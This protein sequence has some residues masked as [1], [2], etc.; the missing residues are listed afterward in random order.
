[1]GLQHSFFELTR[2]T[3]Q[4]Q[5]LITAPSAWLARET[6]R[7]FHVDEKRIHVIP[8]FVDLDRFV[9]RPSDDIRR[10]LGAEDCFVVTHVSNYRP[11][12]H[13]KDVIVGF[14]NLRAR[15]K[16]VLVLVGDGPDLDPAVELAQEL[17]V[18]GDLRILGKMLDLER[19]LQASDL[20]F[21]PSRAESFGLAAL[22][23][24][25]CGVPVIGYSAGGLPEVVVSGETGVLCP[26]GEDVCMGSIA[27]DILG[28]PDR[29]A[30]MKRAARANAERFAIQPI[31]E[32]YEQALRC[33]ATGHDP[34]DVL[35]VAAC[36]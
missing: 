10:K 12:K 5:D 35:D 18:R 24:Q 36:R 19:I 20:F 23:A 16:A 32:R 17:G 13:V 34:A 6:A 11:V 31:L 25:A 2:F 26:E 27:A 8:N 33:L 22:E 29:L 7:D 4:R 14:A 1:V 21:L 15:M 3:I 30:E 28:D 9:P